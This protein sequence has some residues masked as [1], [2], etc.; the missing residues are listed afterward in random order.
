[1]Y[2][3]KKIAIVI[4]D[5]PDT[6]IIML[7]DKSIEQYIEKSRAS[8]MADQDIKEKLVKAGWVPEDVDAILIATT[9]Q[10]PVAAAPQAPGKEHKAH[11]S[12]RAVPD[13]LMD[14]VFKRF[15]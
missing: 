4:E 8:G 2:F 13:K 14:A 7:M 3:K 6:D 12:I 11:F 1:M 9:G 15:K 5:K 10:P